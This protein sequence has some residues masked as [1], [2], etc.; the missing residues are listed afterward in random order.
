MLR[1]IHNCKIRP[2]MECEI[3]DMPLFRGGDRMVLEAVLQRSPGRYASYRKGDF[4][5]LQD[6]VCRTLFLLC[7][8]SVYAQMTSAEGRELTLDTLSAPDTLASAFVFGTEN[9][10]PVSIIAQADCRL[11]VLSRESLREIL[12]QDRTVLHNFLTIISDHSLFLSR[13]I[14]EFALQSLASRV[15]SYLKDNHSIRNLQ[16][17]AFILGVARPSLSRMIGQMV[18]QGTVCKTPDGYTLK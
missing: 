7:E 11:W 10:Y 16:E 3:Y 17:V 4:I 5:A 1:R 9:R 13:R 15:V 18:E 14:N 2:S 8:G 12:E 6:D